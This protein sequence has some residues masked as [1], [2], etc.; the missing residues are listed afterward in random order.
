MLHEKLARLRQSAGLTQEQLAGKMY[1]SR[2]LVSKWEHG[3]RR[4]DVRALRK[5]AEFYGRDLEY[6]LE[7]ENGLIPE[8]ESCA[9]P[10]ADLPAEKLTELLNGFLNTVSARDRGVFVRR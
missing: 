7:D 6:L 3:A 2:E 5:L 4:P 8:L 1:V 10:G 9:P